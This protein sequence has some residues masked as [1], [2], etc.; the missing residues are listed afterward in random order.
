MNVKLLAVVL[1]I[2]AVGLL[3]SRLGLKTRRLSSGM[4]LL[5]GTGTPYIFV[6]LLLGPQGVGLVTPGF[7]DQLGPIVI[8]G[9]GWIGFLYGT[10]FEWRRLRRYKPRMYLGGFFESLL[11]LFAVS[12]AVWALLPLVEPGMQ[13]GF[14]L[15]AS[16]GLGIC[17]AGTA[18]AGV[19]A[20][21]DRPR[22]GRQDIDLLQF[23]SAVDD[24]PAV[25]ALGILFA[26][27][28]PE[29]VAGIGGLTG[30]LTSLALGA[31]LGLVSHLL[32]PGSREGRKQAFIVIL[33]MASL[34]AGAATMLRLSP[35]FVGVVGGV[36]FANLS[37]RKEAIYGLLAQR[38]RTLYAVFLIVAGA[39]LRFE[40]TRMVLVVAPAYA[41]L[42]VTAKVLGANIGARLSA[43]KDAH[44]WLG[45][46]L[47]FQ[48]G[49]GLVI[50]VQL[51]YSGHVSL[52]RLFLTTVV[53]AVVINDVLGMSLA[54]RV[55]RRAA[56]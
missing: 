24:L 15:V 41:L 21:V 18:P 56:P 17:A 44:P 2:V 43:A 34:C 32:M 46:G 35:L 1:A 47:V 25:L 16:V 10:H 33:G 27:L 23:F 14:R 12:L 52:S 54:R 40:A 37:P 30:L 7:L 6:G 13:A 11:T 42:R 38:E 28:S 53:L 3:A 29:H 26:V 45:L 31:V 9:F 8:M 20:L 36:F 4:T 5:V 19:F 22:I 50:A 51:D 39:L 55:L 48:G 49:L